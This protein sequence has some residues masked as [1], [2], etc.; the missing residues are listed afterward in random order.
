[1]AISCEL[2]LGVVAVLQLLPQRMRCVA[3]DWIFLVIR[4]TVQVQ[5]LELECGSVKNFASN[6]L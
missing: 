1:M 6:L 3:C 4:A 5:A 2:S